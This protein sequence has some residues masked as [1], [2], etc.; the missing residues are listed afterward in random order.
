ME[1][2]MLSQVTWL[3]LEELNIHIGVNDGLPNNLSADVVYA[4]LAP[5][6]TLPLH[7]HAR[8]TPDGYEAFFFFRGANIELLL[9]GESQ[10]ISA[11]EPFHLTFV[12]DEPHGLVN[13]DES[14]LIFEVICAP[15][16]VEGEE[17]IIS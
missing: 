8:P 2:R 14:D 4:K 6:A 12:G 11:S 1:M 3:Y 7:K 13:L 15:H 10:I 5:G 16:Y 9:S 17:T